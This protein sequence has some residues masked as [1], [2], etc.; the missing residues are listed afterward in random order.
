MAKKKNGNGDLVYK[1]VT[2][3]I[4]AKLEEGTVP[5]HK[6]WKV[7]GTVTR[8][9][10]G[11]EYRG[12]NSFLL[13]AKEAGG[14]ILKGEKGELVVFWKVNDY[15]KKNEKTGEDEHRKSFILRYYRVF[16]LEQTS[17]TEEQWPK[18]LVE[19][20]TLEKSNGVK[21][22]KKAEKVWK[23]FKGKP[24]FSHG[25][26]R[27]FYRPSDDSMKLPKFEKFDDAEMYHSVKF[28]EMVHST[29]AVVRCGR[30]DPDVHLA[31]FGSEDYSKEELIAEM[32]AAFL[33]AEAGI[34]C[35]KALE[36]SASYIDTWRKRIN[37]DS[38]LVVQAAAAAQK[39]VDHILG[40]KFEE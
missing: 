8:R 35:E 13:A 34:E 32:G 6:P 36:N 24:S 10:N 33:M 29:G 30:F 16:S 12:I 27:A 22:I 37:D 4:L 31:P 28:H 20:R 18:W 38:K 19:T 3:R 39:A 25:G 2:E 40:R 11:K 17:L 1:I 21:P 15:K 5:W 26:D 23:E 14:H 9:W 7:T